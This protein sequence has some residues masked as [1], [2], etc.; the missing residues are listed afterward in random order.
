[1]RPRFSVKMM[2]FVTLLIAVYFALGAPTKRWG[3]GDV[4]AHHEQTGSNAIPSYVAPLL[5]R[6]DS[7]EIVQSKGRN[8][9]LVNTRKY[10]LWLFGTV[11]TIAETRYETPIKPK[12]QFHW[13]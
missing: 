5:V 11:W 1:M 6:L 3:M 2:L 7:S 12:I 8:F 13:Q 4:A 9:D 10:C